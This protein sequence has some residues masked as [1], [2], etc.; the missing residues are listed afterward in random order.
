[1]PLP[2]LVSRVLDFPGAG[3]GSGKTDERSPNRVK[4]RMVHQLVGALLLHLRPFHRIRHR[5]SQKD[6]HWLLKAVHGDDRGFAIIFGCCHRKWE[7]VWKFEKKSIAVEWV[8]LWVRAEFT[9]L[10]QA[11]S[12]LGRQRDPV[13]WVQTLDAVIRI[14]DQQQ[15][16]VWV[17]PRRE[18]FEKPIHGA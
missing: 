12:G 7:E 8:A 14:A 18:Q 6:D 16:P 3:Y 10:L 17:R 9:E 13:Y 2:V 15:G 5:V 4:A 11:A 1:M